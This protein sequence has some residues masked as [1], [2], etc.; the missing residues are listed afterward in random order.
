METQ[1]KT[2]TFRLAALCLA[3]SLCAAAP[4][5]AQAP[6]LTENQARAIATDAYVYFYPLILMDLTRKQ[7]ING[8]RTDFGQGPM[9]A[10][11]NVPAY[12]PADFKGVVRS[13]FD[14]LYSI[15]WLDL[16]RE[17]RGRLRPRHRRPVLSPPDARHVD[18]CLR[19]A[20]LAHDRHPGG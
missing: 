5:V 19:V 11:A 12:P 1:V 8:T 15:A 17:P 3:L 6:A 9:N 7:S 20:W 13:N 16:T 10:F 4:A 18:G 2:T 14:T